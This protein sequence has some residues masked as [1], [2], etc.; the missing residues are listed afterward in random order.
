MDGLECNEVS[1]SKLK[2]TIIGSD[3]NSRKKSDAL[4]YIKSNNTVEDYFNLHSQV[5]NN[6]NNALNYDLKHSKGNF[7]HNV[8]INHVIN[9]T[10]KK[11]LHGDF[12]ISRLRSYLKECAVVQNKSINQVCSTEYL[13]Y[14]P[15]TMLMSSNTLMCFCLT[16]KVQAILNYSQYGT[17]HPRFYEFVLN[18]MPVPSVLLSINHKIEHIFSVIYKFQTEGLQLYSK[19]EELLISELGLQDCL[20][21]TESISIKSISKSFLSTGRLDAEYYQPKYEK[22]E[23]LLKTNDTV[24]TLCN[25]YDKNFTPLKEKKYKYIELSNVGMFG[26]I[27]DTDIIT[28]KKL[29]SRARRKIK[30]NQVIIASVEGSL[31]SCALITEN[32]NNILCSTGF[33]VLNSNSINSETVLLLFKSKP[34]QMLLKQRCSG[35]ILT[36]ITKDE[37]LKMPFP[38]VNTYIQKQIAEKIQKSFSLRHKS[39]ELFKSAIKAVEIAIEQGE[40]AAT[41]WLDENTKNIMAEIGEIDIE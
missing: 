2:E 27:F 17:E 38:K 25:L 5:V 28:G 6:V 7:L 23:L 33:Y 31:E 19:A 9:T 22:Y 13:I 30:S 4:S 26:N 29:P 15:K 32:C 10:K 36:A 34:I 35:T 39:E 20:I 11:I 3:F 24:G 12:I 21:S 1:Y 37:L 14:R 8:E 16:D 41:E 18:E 40:G